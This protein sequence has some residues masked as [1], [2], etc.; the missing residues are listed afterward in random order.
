MEYL[1]KTEHT[2][3]FIKSCILTLAL[4]LLTGLLWGIYFEEYE[5]LFDAFLSG[6]FTPNTLFPSWYYM[7]HI[8]I[9]FVYAKLYQLCPNIEWMSWI[10]YFYLWLS[11]SLLLFWM[12]RILSQKISYAYIIIFQTMIFFMTM[13]DTVVHFQYTRVCYFMCASSLLSL[14]ILSFNYKRSFVAKLLVL[15]LFF[16]SALTRLETCMATTAFLMVFTWLYSNNITASLKVFAIPSIFIAIVF[17]AIIYDSKTTHSFY[18]LVEP[19]IEIELTARNNHVPISYM[20]TYADSLKY[21]AAT[22]MLW[23]DP[24]IISPSFLRSLITKDYSFSSYWE[25]CYRT[26][27]ML[28]EYVQKHT[29]VV[30]LNIVLLIVYLFFI[31]TGNTTSSKLLFLLFYA[32]FFLLIFFQAYFVKVNERTLSSCLSVLTILGF[33]F[34]CPYVLTL[35]LFK[36]SALSTV[37]IIV[38]FAEVARTNYNAK[39]MENDFK[40][41]KRN[42]RILK[43]YAGG[44]TIVL[45]GSTLRTFTTSNRPFVAFCC[46]DYKKVYVN[47]AQVLPTIDAYKMYLEKECK[48]DVTDFSNFFSYLKELQSDKVYFFSDSSRMTLIQEYLNGIHHFDLNIQPIDSIKFEPAYDHERADVLNLKLYTFISQGRNQ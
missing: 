24:N 34:I 5:A 43:R 2:T 17:L 28:R 18:K 40:I 6:C 1:N 4:F 12:A 47:E 31:P 10:L 25:Q 48:C 14:N 36:K 21:K 20:K 44:H 15:F 30:C 35:S 22:N 16:A 37:C 41:N 27:D 45:N 7:G 33:F 42:M 13:A 19:E 26:Y 9:S 39:E 11:C 38:L 3:L 29:A 23:G 32:C 8:G 46:S